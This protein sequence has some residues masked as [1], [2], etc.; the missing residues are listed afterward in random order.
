MLTKTEFARKSILKGLCIGDNPYSLLLIAADCIGTISGDKSFA[1]MCRKNISAVHAHGLHDTS[2]S[3]QR[4]S[5]LRANAEAIR[6]AINHNQDNNTR[7]R[8]KFSLAQI[9]NEE[10]RLILE[11]SGH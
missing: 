2:A 8:L 5:E 3:E 6:N 4:I 10:Q 7:E 1:E 9:E 11:K